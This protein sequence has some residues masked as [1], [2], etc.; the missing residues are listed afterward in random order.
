MSC[1][2]AQKLR[3]L[4]GIPVGGAP[5]NGLHMWESL[6]TRGEAVFVASLASTLGYCT[7]FGLDFLFAGPLRHINCVASA[8]GVVDAYNRY[9]LMVHNRDRT[10]N[11]EHPIK[12]MFRPG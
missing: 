4:T 3:E 1:N 9:N 10:F 8:Q 5:C 12:A 6:K 11:N 2:I 7:A